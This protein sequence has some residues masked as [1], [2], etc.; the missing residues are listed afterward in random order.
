MTVLKEYFLFF[1]T[2]IGHEKKGS[3]VTHFLDVTP[4]GDL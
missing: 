2:E 3:D 1:A 4:H